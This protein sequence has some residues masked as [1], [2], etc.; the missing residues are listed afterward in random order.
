[1]KSPTVANRRG[2]LRNGAG[3]SRFSACNILRFF[4]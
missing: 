4:C 2:V 1:M 3:F